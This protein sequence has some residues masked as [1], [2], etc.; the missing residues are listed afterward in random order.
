MPTRTTLLKV[1]AVAA[2]M[3]GIAAAPASAS[4]PV[5][6]QAVSY[7]HHCYGLYPG[8]VGGYN[9]VAYAPG[10]Y[11]HDEPDIAPN[12][13]TSGT[14][15]NV[16]WTFYLPKDGSV[17]VASLG[18]TFWLGVEVAD[19][20]SL[21]GQ[22]FQEIQFYPDSVLAGQGTTPGSTS[23]CTPDGGFNVSSS[24]GHWTICSPTWA[25]N[26]STFQEYAAF[27]GMVRNSASPTTAFVMNSGDKISVHI[28][29]GSQTG[30]PVNVVVSDLTLGKTA[31]TLVTTA[32]AYNSAHDGTLTTVG[33]ANNARTNYLYW[34]GD[35]EPPFS[36]AWEIGHPNFYAYPRAPACYP[37][38]FNCYSYNVGSGWQST[39][40]LRIV[41]THFTIGS[42]TYSPTSWTTSDGQ[43]GSEE[44]ILYCGSV[45]NPYGGGFCTFPWYSKMTLPATTI[46]AIAFGG[47]YNGVTNP[48][49]TW[50]QFTLTPTCSDTQYGAFLRYCATTLQTGTPIGG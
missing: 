18:P 19:S 5:P 13:T 45:N 25:V 1:L 22:A 39:T 16:T 48:Y 34:G 28:F 27:N 46:P 32:G 14:T 9:K 21:A 10:C 50:G 11:G 7:S 30:T 47:W 44:D 17:S 2:A 49:N 29:K 12:Q 36:L 26:P 8:K 3:A 24:P 40:P 20:H 37:G 35:Q 4:F 41:G 23:G 43:G 15:S 42:T 31:A 6:G 38:M 33:G